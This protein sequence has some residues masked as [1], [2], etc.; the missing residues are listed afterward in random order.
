MKRFRVGKVSNADRPAGARNK[1]FRANLEK[2]RAEAKARQALTDKLTPQARLK[3][4]D[5]KLGVGIGALKE[6][7][8]LAEIIKNGG[9]KIQPKVAPV[10]APVVATKTVTNRDQKRQQR[11]PAAAPGVPQLP[12]LSSVVARVG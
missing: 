12:P 2:R 8:K 5:A 1:V 10:A 7:T 11:N 4:L 3:A 9:K 6:R